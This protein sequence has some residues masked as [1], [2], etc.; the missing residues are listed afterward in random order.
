MQTTADNVEAAISADM[1][2]LAVK[3]QVAKAV[4]RELGSKAFKFRDPLPP[5]PLASPWI[6]YANGANLR[7]ERA[8]P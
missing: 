7:L 4:C 6:A 8:R 3:P 5:S 1:I 2:I